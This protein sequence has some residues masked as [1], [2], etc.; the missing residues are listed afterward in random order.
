MVR[1]LVWLSATLATFAGLA[2]ATIAN[3]DSS[4]S[5]KPTPPDKTNVACGR[6]A[7]MGMVP[8]AG[9]RHIAAADKKAHVYTVRVPRGTIPPGLTK[10]APGGVAGTGKAMVLPA[11]VRRIATAVKGAR[12]YAVRV[13]RGATPPGLTKIA[14]RNGSATCKVTITT[15]QDHS[16]GSS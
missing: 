7:G 12:L 4:G 5:D 14:D 16:R 15:P 10:I 8:P 2:G 6:V 13:P 11:G 9:A 1:R 3:A